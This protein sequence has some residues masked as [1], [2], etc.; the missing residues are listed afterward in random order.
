VKA[1][2]IV[3]IFRV[4]CFRPDVDDAQVNPNNRTYLAAA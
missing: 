2:E 4:F 1:I 3:P